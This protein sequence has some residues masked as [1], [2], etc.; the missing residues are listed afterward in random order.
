MNDMSRLSLWSSIYTRLPS[1]VATDRPFAMDTG[2]NPADEQAL[3]ELQGAVLRALPSGALWW[4]AKQLLVV[5]DLHLGR[6]ER[7]AREGGALLPPYE[8]AETLNR[9]D[10][11]IGA[12]DPRLVISLGDSFDD[13]A[14]AGNFDKD[15]VARLDRMAAGRRLIWI[16]GNHD[17][18]PVSL[19]GTHL[20]HAMID[21]LHFRH[22]AEP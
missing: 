4:P 20:D 22:I 11:E 14:A 7:I 2:R 9:L 13:L 16:A 15:V 10:A 8:T 6:A 21:G 12:H 3:I 18:G 19:P 17:P 1:T 5:A